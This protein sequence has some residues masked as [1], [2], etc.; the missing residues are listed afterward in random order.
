MFSKYTYTLS[1][2]LE[3]N[4]NNKK[5][6]K[7][8]QFLINTLEQ[9]P[10]KKVFY[11]KY[12]YLIQTTLNRFVKRPDWAVENKKTILKSLMVGK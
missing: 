11:F 4:K 2:L 10:Q 8:T 1:N 12:C 5:I 3:N 6:K 9:K 7:K